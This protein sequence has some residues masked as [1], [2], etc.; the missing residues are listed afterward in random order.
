MGVDISIGSLKEFVNL[1]ILDK[2]SKLINNNNNDFSK[3]SHLV[4]ADMGSDSLTRSDHLMTHS[5]GDGSYLII[6]SN[7]IIIK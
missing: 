6:I 4:C 5:W 2:D 7:I 1:R 3:I